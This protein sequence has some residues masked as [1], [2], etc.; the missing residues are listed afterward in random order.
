MHQNMLLKLFS[1]FL[2]SR[3]NNCR[4]T[5][6]KLNKIKICTFRLAVLFFSLQI[7]KSIQRQSWKWIHFFIWH[8][9]FKFSVSATILCMRQSSICSCNSTFLSLFQDPPLLPSFPPTGLI[10]CFL[11]KTNNNKITPCSA[12]KQESSLPADWWLT[13]CCC[14]GSSATCL[15]GPLRTLFGLHHMQPWPT[16]L[17]CVAHFRG[18][19]AWSGTAVAFFIVFIYLFSIWQ[20][21]TSVGRLADNMTQLHTWRTSVW[22]V[23]GCVQRCRNAFGC[24]PLQVVPL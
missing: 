7:Q 2:A 20:T 14:R 5:F 4:K 9:S 22:R 19:A 21:H 13:S 3:Q 15:L 1:F 18:K 6:L 10:L 8:Y 17:D 16:S 23:R 12:Q 11:A 24:N